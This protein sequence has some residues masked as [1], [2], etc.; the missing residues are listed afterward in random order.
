[1]FSRYYQLDKELD[2]SV[3]LF[4]ARQT[5]K[6]TLL[7]QQFPNAEYIDLLDSVTL[8]KFSN[9]PETLFEMYKDSD[10]NTVVI[11]DEI[12]QVP[13]LLNEVHRLIHKRGI[14]FILCG[15]SARK[16]RRKGYNTLGGRAL[17]CYLYP[18]V[19]AEIPDFDIDTALTKGMLPAFYTAK[20]AYRLLASYLDVY[21]RQE[22]KEEALVR[23]LSNFQRF[24][25][26]AALT[27]GEIVNYNNIATDCGVSANSV[28]EYFSILEDTLVGYMIPAFTKRVK[29]RIVLSPKFYFFDIG[30]TN[31]LLHRKEVVRG[32]IEYGH[33]FEH[34]V[35]QELI[36]YI[37]YTHNDN[38]LSYW[39]TKDGVEVDAVIGNDLLGGAKLAIE[40]KSTE[41]V[42]NKHLKGLRT[43]ADEH[44]DCRRIVVA[45]DRFTRR[46][47]DNIEIMYVYDFLRQLWS[48]KLF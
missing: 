27:D 6:T 30:V 8:R 19:S 26:A 32:T 28:K 43:F 9:Y 38:R 22:I 24:L 14:R 23:N 4:G 41:D 25:D 7:L 12:Q 36:A 40:I 20:N 11:I 21:L 42:Q 17:P 48:G 31:Y 34:F 18:L 37:G 44:P 35:M 1:M 5:G 15:S 29:R 13:L 10:S 45:L 39:R 3:F 47:D 46:T 2:T 33:A 16:L